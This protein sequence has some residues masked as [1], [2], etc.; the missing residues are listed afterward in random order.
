[1]L[2]ETIAA[3]STGG[4]NTGI[5]IIRISGKK[6]REIIDK[7]FTSAGRL[8]HQKIIYGKIKKI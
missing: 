2:T 6:S 4:I 1:M 7:I 5:N 3:V 8:E